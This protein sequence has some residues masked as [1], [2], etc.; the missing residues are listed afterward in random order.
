MSASIEY[1]TK[2][3]PYSKA[4]LALKLK[5]PSATFEEPKISTFQFYSQCNT[6]IK[7]KNTLPTLS[8]TYYGLQRYGAFSMSEP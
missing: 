4:I 8:Y 5:H 7:Y 6:V 3:V 2:I 1:H